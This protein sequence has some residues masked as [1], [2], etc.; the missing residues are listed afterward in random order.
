MKKDVDKIKI[1]NFI[2]S[3]T[4]RLSETEKHGELS[5][6]LFL[7]AQLSVKIKTRSALHV[8]HLH[9]LGLAGKTIDRKNWNA[10]L[11]T[12]GLRSEMWLYSYEASLKG[13]TGGASSKFVDTDQ[14]FGEERSRSLNHSANSGC[15]KDNKER[16]V[17]ELEDKVGTKRKPPLEL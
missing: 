7:A 15:G 12:P 2:A 14:A 16:H 6:L 8:C 13:W 4:R 1:G 5:W 9:S 10:S 11:N 3:N 17:A